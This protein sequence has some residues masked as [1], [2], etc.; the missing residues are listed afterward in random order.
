MPLKLVLCQRICVLH[1]VYFS[2]L[3]E[4]SIGHHFSTVASSTSVVLEKHWLLVVQFAVLVAQYAMDNGHS[5]IIF[6]CIA[7]KLAPARKKLHRLV[8]T[9]GMFLQLWNLTPKLWFNNFHLT[10]DSNLIHKLNAVG[11]SILSTGIFSCRVSKV[12][13]GSNITNNPWF[14]KGVFA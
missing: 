8:S 5:G 11:Y 4:N 1:S 13:L 14:F 10:T 12:F 2:N 3:P 6:C 7:Q 9:V